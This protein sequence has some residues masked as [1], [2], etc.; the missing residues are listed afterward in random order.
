MN[1]YHRI[2]GVGPRGF[3]INL[4]LLVLALNVESI[5]GLPSI[6][7]NY[8]ARWLFF[9]LTVA[10]AVILVVWSLKS[11]PPAVRGKELVTT[12]AYRYFRHPIYA[13]FLTCL[14]FGIAVLF[15]NWIYILWAV[16][17]HIVWHWNIASEEKLM[18]RAFPK[19]YEEYCKR[20][21]RF[22]PGIWNLQPNRPIQP[23]R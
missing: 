3:L 13:A 8:F 9:A 4:T 14:N 7:E 11:L 22:I 1:T 12:G 10:G 19:K 17:I 2:F 18:R 20:T 21:R 6:T 5:A 16:F 23:T 15:N